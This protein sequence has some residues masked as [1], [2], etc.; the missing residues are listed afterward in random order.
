MSQDYYKHP[1]LKFEA[2]Q[3]SISI[4]LFKISSHTTYIN[5]ETK[6]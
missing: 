1:Q 3:E 6:I 4:L 5:L 2:Y